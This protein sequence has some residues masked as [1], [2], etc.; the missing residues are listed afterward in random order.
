MKKIACFIVP[1]FGKL[2]NYFQLFL[3]SCKSNTNFEWLII[4]D[5]DTAYN[6]PE[7]VKRKIC[8]FKSFRNKVQKKFDFKIKLESPRKLC[9]FKPAYGYILED[10]LR[11]FPYWGFCDIDTIMGNLNKLL[12]I[13]FISNYDKLFCLGH[14]E[15]FKNNLENNRLFMKDIDGQYWY[16]ESFTTNKITVFDE[17][18]G[19]DKNINT[20]FIK[21]NKKIFQE[22]W[23]FNP[24][25]TPTHFQRI[26]YNYKQ[27]RFIDEPYR[28]SICIWDGNNIYR[29]LFDKHNRIERKEYLYVHLQQRKMKL[30][31]NVQDAD[32][33]TIIP[34]EFIPMN[35]RKVKNNNYI[36]SLK[37]NA[38]TLHHLRVWW[39]W[40]ISVKIK[41]KE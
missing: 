11:E 34:N 13:D 30:K 9:D 26:V 29:Y 19:S 16:K 10:E 32:A 36:R 22:D 18:Y 37:R 23:S 12:K 7:N 20:I 14:F 4:T 33:F 1:Y 21:N 31:K 27:K 25:I 39:H 35:N 8:T 3:N 15:L 24:K 5:D 40:N 28:K 38:F 17:T 6:Y 2:P 41:N